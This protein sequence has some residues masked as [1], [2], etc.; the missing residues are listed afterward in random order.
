MDV[1]SFDEIT[2]V[3]LGLYLVSLM[4]IGMLL[5]LVTGLL[6]SVWVYV[7]RRWWD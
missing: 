5:G 4:I 2:W 1:I 3:R 6:R 7:A